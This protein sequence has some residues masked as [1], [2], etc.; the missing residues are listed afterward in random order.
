MEE[1]LPSCQIYNIGG[2]ENR[3]R[4]LS[5]QPTYKEVKSNVLRNRE[6]PKNGK[7][8]RKECGSW[9]TSLNGSLKLRA[10]YRKSRIRSNSDSSKKA[11]NQITHKPINKYI[12]NDIELY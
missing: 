10:L 2:I 3:S 8:L 1:N 9:W 5:K 11:K 6:C 7:P 12:Y 4:I